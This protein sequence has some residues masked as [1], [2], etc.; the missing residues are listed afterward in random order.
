MRM[1]RDNTS[2]GRGFHVRPFREDDY[3]RSVEMW[4]RSYP[5]L[6]GTVEEAQYEEANWDYHRYARLRFV[7]EDGGRAVVGFGRINHIPDEF[8]ADKY[9]LDVVVDPSHRRRGVGGA[10]YERLIAEL[11]AR[12]AIAA[13]SGVPWETEIDGIQFLA[14]R[15]FLEVQRGWQSRLNVTAVDFTRFAGAEDCAGI[16]GITFTT[17]AA[18]QA[19]DPET[20]RKAYELTNTCEQ[21]IP[22]ADPVTA[23]S[24]EHFLSYAVRSPNTLP[25]AFFLATDGQRYV[26]LSALYR[27]L[28]M[29]DVLH[30]GLTGV[31]REYRG[32]GIAMV[33]KVRTVRYARERGY[34]E[35]RTW[36]DER[37]QPMLRINTALGFVKQP[38]WVS[39][40]KTL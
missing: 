26:G 29:P 12:S 30:Q 22:S 20:L 9:Y 33:L 37:N 3:P 34:R 39:F 24:Y 38:A 16:R 4:N 6:R 32:R 27:P 1:T 36:N 8:Q 31:L 23:T 19:R 35:I 5:D 18:E 13:R 21:D 7:A 10:V 14:H 40:E 11:R 17:L 25:D 28:A 2:T 15:G